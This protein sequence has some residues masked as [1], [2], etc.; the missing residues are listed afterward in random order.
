MN[1]LADR[2]QAQLDSLIAIVGSDPVFGEKFMNDP[3][4]LKYQ[5]EGAVEGTRT[6]AESWGKLSAG[7]F[8]AARNNEIEE[9]KRHDQIMQA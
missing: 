2:V 7:Q 1:A 9:Q 8:K 4:G 3:K 5:L 6:M